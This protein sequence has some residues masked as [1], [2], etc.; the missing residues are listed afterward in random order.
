MRS[1]AADCTTLT[2][3]LCVAVRAG[4]LAAE[5]PLDGDRRPDRSSMP[6]VVFTDPNLAWASLTEEKARERGRGGGGSDAPLPSW[7]VRTVTMRTRKRERDAMD[8]RRGNCAN[9]DLTAG[10]AAL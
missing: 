4:A 7:D 1:A 2:Q 6:A 3:F 9:D 8:G 5:N 10:R